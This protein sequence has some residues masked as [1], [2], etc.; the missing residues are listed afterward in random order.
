ML[1]KNW[2]ME[3]RIESIAILRYINLHSEIFLT[4]FYIV[5]EKCFRIRIVP[6]SPSV[7][8]L[9]L[10]NVPGLKCDFHIL[11]IFSV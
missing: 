7:G 6:L 9:T 11:M 2:I 5:S 1:N 8:D 4:L 10:I 3:K